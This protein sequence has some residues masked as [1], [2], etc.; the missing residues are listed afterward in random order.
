ME[1]PRPTVPLFIPGRPGL[2]PPP[3]RSP[4]PAVPLD[5]RPPFTGRAPAAGVAASG[6]APR[7]APTG[8]YTSASSG[9][10]RSLSSARETALLT[11]PIDTPRA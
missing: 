11:V 9:S 2:D 10:S 3:S 8:C 1:V 6:T 7:T 5:G 4:A